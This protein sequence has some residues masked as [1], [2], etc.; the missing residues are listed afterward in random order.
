MYSPD[1]ERVSSPN[2]LNTSGNVEE[3]M[4]KVEKALKR[5]VRNDLTD[6]QS[7]KQKDTI[8]MDEHIHIL[9]FGFFL[10]YKQVF[11]SETLM[12]VVQTRKF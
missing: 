5:L 12:C 2:G 1:D 10:S 4:G 9:E 7:M 8:I 6:H 11:Y 3:W